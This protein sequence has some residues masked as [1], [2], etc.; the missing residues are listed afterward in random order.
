MASALVGYLALGTINP[1]TDAFVEASFAGYG[2]QPVAFDL[3]RKTA[4]GAVDTGGSVLRNVNLVTFPAPTAFDWPSLNAYAVF[5]ALSGGAAQVVVPL[6]ARSGVHARTTTRQFQV[7]RLVLQVANGIL[8]SP[9]G[10]SVAAAVP[11]IVGGV[12]TI[13]GTALGG[14]LPGA[15]PLGIAGA[16]GPAAIGRYFGFAPTVT[17][18]YGPQAFALAG[19]LPDGL[20]FSATTGAI[21]GFATTATTATGLSI[22]VTDDSGTAT[23]GPFAIVVASFVYLADPDGSR[24]TDADGAYLMEAA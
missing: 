23:L 18:G 10:G 1:M 22:T 11:A 9:F 24:L 7:G 16:P 3:D 12:L 14:T 17:G 13:A 6:G 15:G 8:L 21:T 4:G 19:A 20:S 2:R 5:A